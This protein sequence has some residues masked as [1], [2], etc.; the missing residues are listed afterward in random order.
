MVPRIEAAFGRLTQNSY[1][2]VRQQSPADSVGEHE[3]SVSLLLDDPVGGGT[4]RVDLDQL[5]YD[6]STG[7]SD[8]YVEAAR[9]ALSV[10]L[11]IVAAVCWHQQACGDLSGTGLDGRLSV[12]QSDSFLRQLFQG[13]TGRDE[14]NAVA[15]ALG[16]PVT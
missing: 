10:T 9:T 3:F 16:F 13:I 15:M 1:A 11:G 8:G 6:A 2:P 12:Q 7:R 5:G 14:S 4:A